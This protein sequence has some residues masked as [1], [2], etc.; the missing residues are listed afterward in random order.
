MTFASSKTPN[1]TPSTIAAVDD[2]MSLLY[3][4]IADE[5]AVQRKEQT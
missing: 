4:G 1:K 5:E 3:T 2:D